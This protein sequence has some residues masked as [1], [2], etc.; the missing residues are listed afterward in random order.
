MKFRITRELKDICENI[1]MIDWSEEEWKK[2][3]SEDQFVTNNFE[4]GYNAAKN[5]FSFLYTDSNFREY[6]IEIPLKEV[7]N[8]FSGE[9]TSLNA[10]RV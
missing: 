1:L 10:K 5:L 4:G 3:S 2:H 9:I 7:D 6:L 8:I